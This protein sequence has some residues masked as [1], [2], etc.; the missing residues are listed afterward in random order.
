MKW[1][2]EDK[3]EDKIFKKINIRKKHKNDEVIKD[4]KKMNLRERINR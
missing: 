2:G 1:C 3:N 4:K